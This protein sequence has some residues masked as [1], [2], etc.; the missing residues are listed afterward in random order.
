MFREPFIHGLLQVVDMAVVED[1]NFHNERR[2]TQHFTTVKQN[3]Q[4]IYLT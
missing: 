2:L 1:L 3:L 4:I